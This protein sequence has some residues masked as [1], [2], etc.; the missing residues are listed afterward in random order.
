MSE[1]ICTAEDCLELLIGLRTQDKFEI[2]SSDYTLLHSIGRQVYRGISMT[3]RQ[4]ELIKEKLLKYKNQFVALNYD[5]ETYMNHVR[6]P[7]R[8][9]DRAR[10][11]KIEEY[12]GV[13]CIAVRFVFQKKLITQMEHIKNTLEEI[14]YDK[15]NKT[16]YFQFNEKSVYELVST[17]SEE[18]GFEIDSFLKEYYKKL[19][20]MKNNKDEYLPGIYGLKLKNLHEK[21]FNYAISSMGEPSKDNL[22]QFY[23]QRDRLGLYHFDKDEVEQS[24]KGLMTLSKKI[25]SRSMNHVLVSPKEYT[26]DNLAES[27]L[28]L[29]RF[30]LIVV[31]NEKS[32]YDELV[33]FHRA[34]NGI[35]SNSSCSVM[36]RLDNADGSD[37]NEYIRRNELNSP[38]DKN[39]KI[40]YINNNKI[41]KPLLKSDWNPLTAIT[42]QSSYKGGSNKVDVYLS[43]LD[44]VIHYDNEA[45]PWMR[46]SIEK[47]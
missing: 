16:H 31:L 5:V 13:P 26:V 28:E 38:V 35:I 32:C 40:V 23:D 43:N 20:H 3:D 25:V 14:H 15:E 47:I 39:T 45:S 19:E 42:T 44:L 36:F 8:T 12:N 21:S 37:F 41:P 22:F 11:I 24:L 7:L 17:F 33:K 29:Y 34:F 6:M 30:P 18:R 2:E 4:H 46:K 1:Q 10:W 9:I 27:I